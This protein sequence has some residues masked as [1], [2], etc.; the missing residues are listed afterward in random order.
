MPN[1][2]FW[3]VCCPDNPEKQQAEVAATI[4]AA[5]LDDVPAGPGV[6]EDALA[7]HLAKQLLAVTDLAPK[8]LTAAVTA[9]WNVPG[10]PRLADGVRAAY[11]PLF[12]EAAHEG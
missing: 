9:G 4:K 3:R 1:C 7:D 6:R 8:G 10:S 2:C 5:L 11:A 12:A